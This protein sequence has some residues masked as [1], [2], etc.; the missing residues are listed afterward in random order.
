MARPLPPHKLAR[1][2][3]HRSH[4]SGA[5][6]LMGGPALHCPRKGT[7]QDAL[8][9]DAAAIFWRLPRWQ[10]ADGYPDARTETRANFSP[11]LTPRGRAS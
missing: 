11:A 5:R 2:G 1:L 10:K 7:L 3:G 9:R 6:R 8:H 4:V